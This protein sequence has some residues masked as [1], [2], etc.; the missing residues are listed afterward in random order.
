MLL[1]AR[2]GPRQ[3]VE[4]DDRVA[5]AG[6]A[7]VELDDD[8]LQLRL[9]GAQAR[10]RLDRVGAARD[11][12]H[13]ERVL[14]A[15]AREQ[16]ARAALG[17]EVGERRIGAV[18]RDAERVADRLLELGRDVGDEVAALDVRDRPADAVEQRG[19]SSSFA[20]SGRTEASSALIIVSRSRASVA[21]SGPSSDR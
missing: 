18:D 5:L 8:L 3:A 16:L 11:P 17:A 19:R 14:D 21:S 13:A 15:G 10:D 20:L 1:V 4:L 6:D 9:G 7:G 12:L 2:A